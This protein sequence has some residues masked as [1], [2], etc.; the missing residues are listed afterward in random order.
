[1]MKRIFVDTETGGLDCDTDA[2]LDVCMRKE[3]GEELQFYLEP[4]KGL[5]IHQEAL[6]INKIDLNKLRDEGKLIEEDYACQL[7]YDFL[8]GE[9]CIWIGYNVNFDLEFIKKLFKRNFLS[10]PSQ[11]GSR[12]NLDLFS[13]CIFLKDTGKITPVNLKLDT[14]KEYFCIKMNGGVSHTAK[15]DVYTTQKLYETLNER[16]FHKWERNYVQ[17]DKK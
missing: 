1:M 15:A 2:L 14:L 8:A 3:T 16:F 4:A 13:V 9:N 6:A 7:I 10:Y 17:Q 12:Y 11:I 5:I